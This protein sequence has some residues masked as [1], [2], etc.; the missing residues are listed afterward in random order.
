[1]RI[2]LND[3]AE[4]RFLLKM[5]HELDSF[6]NGLLEIRKIN[7]KKS[8]VDYCIFNNNNSKVLYI[9]LKSLNKDKP[10][11]NKHIIN[12]HKIRMIKEHYNNCIIVWEYGENYYF[13]KYNDDIFNFET[14]EIKEQNTLLVPI[15]NTKTGFNRLIDDILVNLIIKN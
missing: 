15:E 4:H 8:F 11:E 7:Y 3:K 12:L 13:Y 5:K 14:K 2:T 1:M 10:Y 6:Y 9:E